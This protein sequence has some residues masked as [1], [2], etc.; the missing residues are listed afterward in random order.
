MKVLDFGLVRELTSS[1]ASKSLSRV[2]AVI[3]TPHYL[4]PEAI[5]TPHQIDARADIYGLGCVA[6]FL[7]TGTPPFGGQ[8]LVEVCAHHLHTEPVPPREHVSI[9]AD[10]E[11]TILSCLV[12]DPKLRPQ[13]AADLAEKLGQC[14]DAEGWKLA[15]AETWWRQIG[16]AKVAPSKKARPKD[17]PQRTICCDFERR[18]KSA[19]N[20]PRGARASGRVESRP[21]TR[22]SYPS[23]FNPNVVL[24]ATSDASR[25]RAISTVQCGERCCGDRRRTSR[26]RDRPRTNRQ[27]PSGSG[28]RG[29]PISPR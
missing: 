27:S 28:W 13:R 5:L 11:T 7:A 3:G 6:Y 22:G 8:T 4:S 16:D 24:I 2:D 26:H 21:S 10:L 9:R 17:E 14:A 25:P 29:M 20:R 18:L 15:D 12:K 1:E 23:V 19:N